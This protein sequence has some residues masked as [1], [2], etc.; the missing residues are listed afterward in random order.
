[1]KTRLV[2]AVWLILSAAVVLS[3]Q[4]GESGKNELTLWGGFSPD[5]TTAITALGRTPDA[6]FGI[7]GLRYSRRFNNSDSYNLKYTADIIPAAIL[8]YPDREITPTLRSVRPTRYGFGI[9]PLGVQMN[10][11]PRK[12]VQPFI[13]LSGGLL[14]FN[15][16]VYNDVGARF[17]FTADIGGGLE[18]R[19][20]EKRAV[21]VGYKYYHISNGGRGTENPGFDN[22]LIYIGYTFFSK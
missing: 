22:N 13:G 10:F 11:R 20:K 14:Y 16:R 4:T 9:A 12:K 18:I 19:L 3:A 15:Q 1:M 2:L 6:R 21:T 8:N 5:S 17:N 7:V